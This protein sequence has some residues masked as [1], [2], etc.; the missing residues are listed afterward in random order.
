MKIG[1][2]LRLLASHPDVKS[3][4]ARFFESVTQASLQ[5]MPVW[6]N[7]LCWFVTDKFEKEYNGKMIS[8]DNKP[9][10][11]GF[12]INSNEKYELLEDINA[13]DFRCQGNL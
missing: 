13:G 6:V 1:D 2:Q 7:Y 9:I 11:L 3:R 5:K 8:Y 4:R 10:D 12:W